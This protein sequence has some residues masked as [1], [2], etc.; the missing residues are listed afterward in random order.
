V[1]VADFT[2]APRP[3]SRSIRQFRRLPFPD[4]DPD[5][6]L[7]QLRAFISAGGHDMLIPADDQALV[8]ITKHYHE[9]QSLLYLACPPPKITHRVLNKIETLDVARA[10]GVLVPDTKV[11]SNSLQL[12]D[13]SDEIRFPCVLKPAAKG[14]QNEEVKSYILR[15]AKDVSVKFPEPRVF[16]PP[17]LLQAYCDGDGVGVEILMQKGQ[18]VAAFQHRRL[19]EYPHTGG[20]SVS[21]IS[22][23]LDSELAE[24]S[25]SLLRALQWEGPAMV[26]F[27]VNREDRRAVL[28]EVNGRYWGTIS[29]PEFAGIDFPTL[30]WQVAHGEFP[31][32]TVNYSVGA[33]WRWTAG[34]LLR[35][36]GM[37]LAARRS[38]S[39]RKELLCNMSDL[40]WLLNPSTHDALLQLSDPL[41]ALL[42]LFRTLKFL[43]LDDL[44]ILVRR[45]HSNGV[46]SKKSFV[47]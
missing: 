27:K 8:A 15:S 44:R 29:L 36:H 47:M 18:I 20:L 38:I 11:I 22:E 45:F 12:S 26:E 1:D 4:A 34:H 17:M 7:R 35:L 5:G 28:M 6:F 32:R 2:S 21:A 46:D 25:V 42:D 16:H 30:H 31:T 37:M 24:K 9:L 39:A 43:V 19:K 13:L 23:P 3:V 41:P 10:C 33:Q 40:P 14:I